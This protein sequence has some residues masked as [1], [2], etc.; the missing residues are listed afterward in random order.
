MKSPQAIHGFISSQLADLQ[1]IKRVTEEPSVPA[2]HP[3]QWIAPP[4]GVAKVN[5]DQL[6]GG[7]AGMELWVQSVGITLV[8]FLG[9]R[10][11]SLER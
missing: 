8:H 4:V 11:L 10:Q 7:R 1:V 5:T 3:S 2:P 9:H 6:L